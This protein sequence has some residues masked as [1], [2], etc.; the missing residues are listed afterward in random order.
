MLRKIGQEG[1]GKEARSVIFVR[2]HRQ[3]QNTHGSQTEARRQ[4]P[5]TRAFSCKLK[6]T[7]AR[8]LESWN[9]SF[10]GICNGG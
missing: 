1:E 7:L 2:L 10:W 6:G 8:R 5:P 3:G 4:V 9:I